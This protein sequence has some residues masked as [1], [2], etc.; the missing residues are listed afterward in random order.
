MRAAVLGDPRAGGQQ[1][2]GGHPGHRVGCLR[3]EGGGL[4]A[5]GLL[6]TVGSVISWARP[7]DAQSHICS[8]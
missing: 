1:A 6:G 3:D 4:R 8:G 2:R 7:Q 5:P